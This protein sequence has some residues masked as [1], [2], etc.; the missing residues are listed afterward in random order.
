MKKLFIIFVILFALSLIFLGVYYLGF[1]D[2]SNHNSSDE[3][4]IFNKITSDDNDIPNQMITQITEGKIIAPALTTG[5]GRIRYVNAENGSIEEIDL[6]GTNKKILF[7]NNF[8]GIRHVAWSTDR[9]KLLMQSA[10]NKAYH[11]FDIED[12]TKE[13]FKNNVDNAVWTTSGNRVLYKY[14][15]E[16]SKERSLNIA[17]ADGSDWKKIAPLEIRNASFTQIPRSASVLYWNTGSAHAK[18]DLRSIGIVGISESKKIGME[19]F[20]A[21]Y[22]P[23]P[24]GEYILLSALTEEAGDKMRLS[25]MNQNGGEL[26]ALDIPTFLSKAIWSKDSSTIFYAL[27]NIAPD[28]TLLP[29]DYQN[30]KFMTR[31]SFWKVDVQSGQKERLIPLNTISQEYDA[32]NLFLSPIEDTLFFV[33]RYDDQ[34]YRLDIAVDE[35]AE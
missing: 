2:S 10:T 4:S 18:S 3:V 14:F 12:G 6:S 25:L 19:P 27:S 34:L 8:T 28:G 35:D 16:K 21:D 15:E 31:D 33:N 11:V 9:Q 24:N 13:P 22:L 23:S 7:E 32:I 30:E 5:G 29:D 1:N 26:R 20:G 17:N